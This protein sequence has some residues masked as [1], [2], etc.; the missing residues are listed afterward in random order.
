MRA[1][2]ACDD[3][4]RIVGDIERKVCA[5]KFVDAESKNGIPVDHLCGECIVWSEDGKLGVEQDVLRNFLDDRCI[6]RCAELKAHSL[7][8]IHAERPILQPAV[9]Y[10]HGSSCR[11]HES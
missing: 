11:G 8:G 6:E 3:D 10:E 7:P 5:E 2:I 9:E 4:L 1:I